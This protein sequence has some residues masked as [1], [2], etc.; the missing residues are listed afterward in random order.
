MRVIFDEFQLKDDLA[1][2]YVC[3]ESLFCSLVQTDFNDKVNARRP[4]SQKS[5]RGIVEGWVVSQKTNE[6]VET[7]L[8]F[9]P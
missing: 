6:R 8:S 4:M 3:A 9:Y 5:L 1:C 7:L 2:M